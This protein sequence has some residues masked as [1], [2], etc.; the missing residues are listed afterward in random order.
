MYV[1]NFYVI[2]FDEIYKER[3]I[4]RKTTWPL[5]KSFFTD[6]NKNIHIHIHKNPFF[7]FKI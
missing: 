3:E 6:K 5:K 4:L 7:F 2:T 1:V